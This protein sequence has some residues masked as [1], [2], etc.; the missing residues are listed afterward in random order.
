[1]REY[2]RKHGLTI[3]DAARRIEIDASSWGQWERTGF[4]AWKRYRTLV[5][6][7]LRM[8]A[9]DDTPNRPE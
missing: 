8:D 3:K 9:E 7:F 5:D 1:M 4:I 2:R 6:E